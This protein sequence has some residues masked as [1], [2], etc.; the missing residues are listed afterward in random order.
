MCY[1]GRSWFNCLIKVLVAQSCLTLH[2]P[3]ECSPPSPLKC[4]W[5]F[6][7]KNTRMGCHFLLQG[8]FPTQRSNLGFL[9][10]RQILCH[11]SHQESQFHSGNE[12]NT[13]TQRQLCL[14]SFLNEQYPSIF[15]LFNNYSMNPF[16][17]DSQ[18]K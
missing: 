15:Q 1:F 18:H 8:I 10:C 4:P 11:Q 6:P 3:M 17:I 13:D 9:H 12:S 16:T 2:D 7:S 5:D 14:C